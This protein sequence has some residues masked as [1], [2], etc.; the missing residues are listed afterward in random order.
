MEDFWRMINENKNYC[1]V[2]LCN[3]MEEGKEKCYMYWP[4]KE[5]EQIQ[6]GHVNVTLQS[7]TPSGDYVIRKLHTSNERV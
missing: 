4:T 2:Q 6:Y 3:I 1:I 7:E 5:G